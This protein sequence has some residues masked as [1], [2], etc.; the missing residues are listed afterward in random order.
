MLPVS[1]LF[2]LNSAGNKVFYKQ[3]NNIGIEYK[4]SIPEEID[5]IEKII[6]DSNISIEKKKNYLKK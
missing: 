6:N 3:K 4:T 5:K 2:L 1:F